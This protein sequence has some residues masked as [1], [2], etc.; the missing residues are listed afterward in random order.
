MPVF[1]G[2]TTISGSIGEPTA[3]AASLPG[4]VPA[5]FETP[6]WPRA[7]RVVIW[8]AIA[9]SALYQIALLVTAITGRV[10]YPYD[11]EW[12]EG[13]MLHHA[14]RI[15]MG[16]GIYI[17]PSVEFI[18]YL[19]TP[20]YP[21]MLA[22]LGGAFGLSYT[23]GRAISVIALGGIVVVTSAAFLSRRFQHIDKEPAVAGVAIALG[24]FAACYPFVD[25]WYDLVRADTFFLFMVTAAIA[26]LNRWL[27]T[28]TGRDR[29]AKAAAGAAILALSFFCKQTGIFYVAVGGAVVLVLAWR[30]VVTYVAVAGAIGLGGRALLNS[31]TDDWFWTY[32]RKI[33]QAH[34]FNMDRFWKSFAHILWHFPAMSIVI[35]ATLLIVVVTWL[36]KPRE[37]P[38]QAIPFVLWTFVF[39]V[40]VIVGAIGY[41]TEFAHFNAYMPALL[42]GA[43]AAGAAV[44]ALAACARVFV[45]RRLPAIA[46]A[47]SAEPGASQRLPRAHRVEEPRASA[48][49][50]LVAAHLGAAAAAIPLAITLALAP[51]EPRRYMPTDADVAAGDRLIERLRGIKGEIWVP[52]HPWYAVLANKR[53]YVHRMGVKDVTVREPRKIEGLDEAIRDRAFAAIVVDK[54]LETNTELADMPSLKPAYHPALKLAR[55]E[56]P[57]VYT[58]VKV[59]PDEIWIATTDAKPPKGVRAV[60]D[61]ETFRWGDWE[62]SGAAWGDGPVEEPLAGHDFVTGVTGQRFATSMHGGDA[63]MGRVVS[64]AFALDGTRLTL[65]LG[66]GSDET[67]LRAELWVDGQIARVASVPRPGGDALQTVS[68]DIAD[69]AGKQAKLV[70]VDDSPTGHLDVDDVWL[71]P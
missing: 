63:A 21:T 11:L 8:T 16:E 33:H 57:H 46:H 65:K 44:P 4:I 26:G 39:G 37:L 7:L 10:G 38:P 9:A 24:L 66:G 28:S 29:H 70:L 19:Y 32:I 52:S 41:G 2:P 25:G 69:L 35:G 23:L 42:H 22:L 49:T 53:P 6:W 18:P 20:L 13:G 43:M 58:G 62:R 68:L 34:D 15:R 56:K 67:K 50:E 48:R 30:C 45:V 31:T 54:N 1:T 17:P 27:R 55:D 36:R 3:T 71:W 64:P 5:R 59:I 12:M 40:S 14:Q 47:D 61:F 51:W 60:F